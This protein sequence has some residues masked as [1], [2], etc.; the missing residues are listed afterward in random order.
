MIN[1]ATYP[2]F[3]W[4]TKRILDLMTEFIG[5][6]HNCLQQFW[7]T[8]IFFRLDTPRELFWLL[9]ELSV[10]F[11]LSLYNLGSDHRTEN[12]SVALQWI[13][14][15][16]HRKYLLQQVYFID[17]CVF[18]VGLFIESLPSNGCPSIVCVAEGVF[19]E[20]FPSNGSTCQNTVTC[21]SA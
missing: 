15:N 6:L 9:T 2:G 21:N 20:P 7:Y 14:V 10:V 13:Y 5:P 1:T 17:G 16:A 4:L 12:T 3:P 19:T 8:V 18:V 11:G